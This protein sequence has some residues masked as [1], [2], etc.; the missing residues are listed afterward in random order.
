MLQYRQRVANWRLEGGGTVRASRWV[1][2]STRDERRADGSVLRTQQDNTVSREK[3][4]QLNAKGSRLLGGEGSEH[5]LVLGGE[6]ESAQLDN[7]RRTLEDGL[8]ALTEYGDNFEGQ[9]HALGGLR[10]GRVALNPTGALHAG[11]RWEGI[12]TQGDDGLGNRPTNRSSV[13]TPLVHLLWKPD[14]KV[15]DQVR[16]SLTR[17]YAQPNTNTLIARPTINRLNSRPRWARPTPRAPRQRRQPRPAART[18]H[19]HRPGL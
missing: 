10:A 5:S 18:G 6:A 3:G 14:P 7:T 16:M 11:L 19:R 17:S 15:R 1:N 9:H 2:E 8:P 4:W 12:T 13:W